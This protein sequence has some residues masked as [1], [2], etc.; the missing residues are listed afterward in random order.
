MPV[1]NNNSLEH[2]FQ[3]KMISVVPPILVLLA[4]SPLVS[5]FDVSSLQFVVSGAAPAGKDLIEEL[6][7][8]LPNLKFVGQ[9]R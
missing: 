3:V 9:G 6:M 4:K 2:P 8:R 1:E 7:Q 5:K